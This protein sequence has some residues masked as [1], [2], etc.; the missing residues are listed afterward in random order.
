[1]VSQLVDQLSL[2]Y[3]DIN[4]TI[5]SLGNET[6][7]QDARV[8]IVL[9]P[10]SKRG[11]FWGWN[12]N[13]TKSIKQTIEK[14][15][16]DLIHIH[17]IW[18]AAQWCTLRIARDYRIPC[19]VSPHGMLTDWLWKNQNLLQNIKKKAYFDLVFKPVLNHK[20]AFHAITPIELESLNRQL[21]ENPKVTIPNAIEVVEEKIVQTKQEPE[22]QFLFLGR[23]TPIK[24]VDIL[25]DA[26]Y[27]AQLGNE[28]KLLLAGPEYV[29]GYVTELKRKVLDFGMEDSII[30]TGSIYGKQK[31]DILQKTWALVIPSHAEVMGMVNLEAAV[32]KVPS[33]TTF[34]TGLWNW[35]EGGGLLVHP[36]VEELSE[37]LKQATLWSIAERI[38]RGNQS[39]KLV[40]K[41][42]SW[43]TI[44]PKWYAF[45]TS[46]MANQSVSKEIQGK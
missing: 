34:E 33:I 7:K 1:M 43:Q 37:A 45:Y 15:K 5:L 16:I 29:P 38:E 19:V 12:R 17:G 24:A 14:G 2:Q 44:I 9:V 6:V 42:Y 39:Y 46:L 22:K 4:L 23:I 28:W 31:L 35:Q 41:N 30:F 40:S 8:N 21:P 26:F 10:S 13:L 27:Q 18:M 11:E 3:E 25:I 36:K 32:Q 20:V